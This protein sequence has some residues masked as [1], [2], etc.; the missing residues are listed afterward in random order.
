MLKRKEISEETIEAEHIARSHGEK[1]N[2]RFV[3]LP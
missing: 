3:D 2:R 1:G